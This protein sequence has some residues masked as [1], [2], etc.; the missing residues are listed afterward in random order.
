MTLLLTLL[1]S[2]ANAGWLTDFC[3]NHLRIA[4]DP[5][6]FEAQ[7]T[8]SVLDQYEAVNIKVRWRMASRDD[9]ELW[10]ILRKEL[11]FRVQYGKPEEVD[12][13]VGVLGRG[14]Y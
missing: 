6:Q 10:G 11:E 5:Q 13:I 9:Q 3:A 2:T 14:F 7:E 1:I 4:Q 12:E 8:E